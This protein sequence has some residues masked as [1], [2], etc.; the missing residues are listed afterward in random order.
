[1]SELAMG[2]D[3]REIVHV[4]A[5]PASVEQLLLA[6]VNSGATVEQLERLMMLRQQM[7]AEA[8]KSAFDQAMADFQRDCPEIIKSKHVDFPSAGGGR[9]K[10]NYAPLE[11]IV[12]QVKDTL[13][14]HGLSYKLDMEVTD[15][16]IKATCIAKHIDGHQETSSFAV[17]ID[18]AAKMSDAQKFASA[19]TF[20]KRYAFVNA[21]GI[22]TADED[23]DNNSARPAQRREYPPASAPKAQQR[24]SPQTELEAPLPAGKPDRPAPER[25]HMKAMRSCDATG[26]PLIAKS[27]K[28]PF[29]VFDL[30]RLETGQ[31]ISAFAWSCD[32]P[33]DALMGGREYTASVV[34]ID[35][36]DG[37]VA[38][39]LHG[40]VQV[41]D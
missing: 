1:M 29:R 15:T 23:D 30:T 18:R 25:I 36:P 3:A 8:A 34:A 14:I 9:V 28:L 38:Y 35:K 39:E 13:A 6:A 16:L 41:E 31:A 19:Q 5:V 26:K 12:R 4:Q 7:R 10:Y 2:D 33:E 27:N 21:F 40:M 22:M 20:A 37:S 24:T 32:W 11:V 17:P